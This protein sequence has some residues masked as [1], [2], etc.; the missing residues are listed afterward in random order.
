MGWPL[1]EVATAQGA[2]SSIYILEQEKVALRQIQR[3]FPRFAD[4]PIYN[5]EADPLV[6]WSLPQPWRADVTYAAMVVKV[7]AQH[8][9]LLV[10]TSPFRYTLLSN[11][12]AFLSYHPYPFS[13]RTLTARFQVNN[14]HPPHVQLVRKPVLTAMALLAL[15]GELCPVHASLLPQPDRGPMAGLARPRWDPH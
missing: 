11:D 6:G 7:I 3:L 5:D 2:G 15:L 13:Q 1:A 4:T 14:T 10:A 9:N 8:Q 12:N